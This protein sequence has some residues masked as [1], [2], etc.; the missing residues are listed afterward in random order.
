[1]NPGKEAFRLGAYVQPDFVAANPDYV[2]RLRDKTGMDLF[3]LRTGYGKDVLPF[4]ED[5]IRIV[6]DEGAQVWFLAGGYWGQSAVTSRSPYKSFESLQ[7]MHFPGPEIDAEITGHLK[8]V[9]GQYKPDAVCMTHV[10]YL[11][12]AYMAGL[13]D[14]DCEDEPYLAR[15]EA[16]GVSRS[17]VN[18]ALADAEQALAASDRQGLLALARKG[19]V[20]F[21]CEL[22][23][24]DLPARYFAFRCGAV[25]HTLRQCR[26]LVKSMGIAFGSNSYSPV[27]AE[28]CGEDFAAMAD[29]CDFLNPLLGNMEWHIFEPIAAWARYLGLHTRL[30]ER[31]AIEASKRLFY[32]GDTLCP[33]SLEELDSCGESRDEVICSMV[34]AQMRLCARAAPYPG[35]MM[36]ALRGGW[37]KAVNDRLMEEARDLSFGAVIALHGCD[38]FLN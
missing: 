6:R 22:A 38:Y 26:E 15:R 32:L 34:S 19:L 25:N 31:S 11:H 17:A 5:A 23:Q 37:S 30:D 29:S 28:V 27:G 21:L 8:T 4:L 14:E 7:L 1:M 18:R 2:K 16:A 35:W 24:S 20:G 3:I 36:P 33:D 12:P 10:R 13:F 9:C